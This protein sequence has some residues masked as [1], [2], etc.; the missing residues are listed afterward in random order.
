MSGEKRKVSKVNIV[1]DKGAAHTLLQYCPDIENW[2]KSWS[3]EESDLAPGHLVVEFFKPFLLHLLARNL[4]ASTLRRH[5]DHLWMLGGEVIRRRQEDPHL[6][7][8]PVEKVILGLLE[9]DGGPLIWPRITK[10]E[11]DAF[12][13]SCR[14]FYR[15]LMKSSEDGNSG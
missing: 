14:K 1:A 8:Q 3:Y 11:Q 10:Q 12:D 15:F 5:R 13:A 7:R 6:C 4:A 2:P 9:E